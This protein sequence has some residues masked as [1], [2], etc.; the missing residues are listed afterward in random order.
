MSD[1]NEFKIALHPDGYVETFGRYLE[2]NVP[3]EK[4]RIGTQQDSITIQVVKSGFI[5]T[6]PTH[7]D[8]DKLVEGGS[9]VFVSE[10]KMNQQ[11]KRVIDYLNDQGLGGSGE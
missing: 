4:V 1:E 7:K 10:R 3:F 6:Y 9:D 5:L 2:S 11:I 8:G